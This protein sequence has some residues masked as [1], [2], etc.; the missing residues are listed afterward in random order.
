MLKRPHRIINCRKTRSHLPCSLTGPVALW[1]STGGGR[2]LYGVL[3]DE[4]RKL[5]KEK[6]NPGSLWN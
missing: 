1:E 4:S 6:V 2:L 5:Q 3:Q